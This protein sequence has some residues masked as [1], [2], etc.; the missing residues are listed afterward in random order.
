MEI[1]RDGAR[2]L[3][4][5]PQLHEV[6]GGSPVGVTIQQGAHNPAVENSGKCLVLEARLPFGPGG[7]DLSFGPCLPCCSRNGPDM[8]TLGVCG[9]TTKAG[10]V[11]RIPILKSSD[12]SHS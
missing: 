8:Q 3:L 2:R 11:G 1:S 9:S 6:V 5:S 12:L 7:A 10:A 4:L